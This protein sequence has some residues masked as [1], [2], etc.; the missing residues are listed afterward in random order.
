MATTAPII[1]PI[2]TPG[3]KK[4]KDL[5]KRMEA[6]EK[7][8]AKLN[9]TLPR[10]TNN[11]KKTGRALQLQHQAIFSGL[12]LHS[13]QRLPPIVA[14]FGAI[15]QLNRSLSTL[16]EREADTLVLA[17]NLQNIGQGAEK[18][19]E[20]QAIADELDL[21]TLFNSEDF[22][23]GFALLTSFKAIGV[24]SYERVT[25]AAA[26]LATITGTDLKSAQLQ[27]A[28][29]LENPV[30]GM[31]ALSRSGTTFTKTQKEFVKQLVESNQALEAQNYILSIV[32]GQYRGASQ[33]AAQ[34]YA[35]A[36]DT[37][38]K[39]WRD[40]NE[41]IGKTIQPAATAFLNAL[42]GYL[43]WAKDEMVKTA[44]ALEVMSGW[45]Q[46]SIGWIQKI[47]T[48]MQI[49]AGKTYQ[50]FLKL[51]EL[52]GL[53]ST[54][55]GWGSIFSN[56]IV[57]IDKAI[58]RSLPII[59]QYFTALDAMR[60][61]RD[62]IGGAAPQGTGVD[63]NPLQGADLDMNAIRDQQRWADLMNQFK[64]DQDKN[65]TNGKTLSDGTK[66]IRNLEQKLQL[67]ASANQLEKELLKIRFEE[68]NA[69]KRIQE[70]VAVGNQARAIELE[71]LLSKE[72]QL[73]AIAN[74][75]KS[76]V[77]LTQGLLN[78]TAQ[79]IEADA[80][81][82]DLIAD[83]INPALADELVRIEQT[84]DKRREG[85]ELVIKSAEAILLNADAEDEATKALKKRIEEYKKLLDLIDESEGEAKRM[86]R[87]TTLT[88]Q[89]RFRHTLIN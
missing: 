6:L 23:K 80:R 3:L 73:E 13:V 59:G 81:R 44:K 86:P 33:A 67:L 69:I 82:R 12:A 31:S 28:K 24:D 38:S 56:E 65:K 27:L 34:G 20:L 71:Q 76:E 47:G 68:E 1:L 32:E 53:R 37:L 42:A 88:I 2:Q 22:N 30:E 7:D 54:F 15:N 52:V 74:F 51:S 29:A 72:Q 48:E 61:L 79:Q 62:G 57:E 9:R 60:R 40:V 78:A 19:K 83:G 46:S 17:R 84:Y 21:A 55:E 75:G 45:I 66:E 41:Q 16:A 35:G 89:A 18:L 64:L 50:W 58:L 43:E 70:T 25:K 36:L 85:L 77:E 14:T 49:A 39:R 63:N 4:I 5:E 26:D 87:T 10:T 8:V 11:I